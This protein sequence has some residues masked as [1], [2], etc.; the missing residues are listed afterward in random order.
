M[1]RTVEALRGREQQIQ[2]QALEQIAVA[3]RT[4]AA[5][6]T[7]DIEVVGEALTALGKTSKDF[8]AAIELARRRAEWQKSFEKL[9]SER[10]KAT[11]AESSLQAE[12]ERFISVRDAYAEKAASLQAEY[13]AANAAIR[14][15]DAARDR[16]L[17]PKNVPGGISIE[18]ADAVTETRAGEIE[19]G[20]AEYALG[21]LDRKL[22]SVAD[23]IQ[24]IAGTEPEKI[25]PS[26]WRA[27]A[28]EPEWTRD[29][30]H[31]ELEKK[32]NEWRRVVRDREAARERLA[33][34]TKS[35]AGFKKR[36]DTLAA[37]VVKS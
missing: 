5:G 7:T 33:T 32:M 37:Q 10:S 29:G 19:R 9:P 14:E 15:G 18:Y 4:V 27:K 17:D 36:R 31:G 12:Y 35:A 23:W 26:K 28:G 6:G 8:D 11:R 34:A 22:A 21:E 13:E 1:T 30:H 16:L 2:R 20:A 25:D 24:R 3:A